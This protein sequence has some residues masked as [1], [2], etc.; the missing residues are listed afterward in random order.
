M[1]A[2]VY[3][4]MDKKMIKHQS[5]YMN[6]ALIFLQVCVSNKVDKKSVSSE[7]FYYLSIQNFFDR[8]YFFCH[9][10]VTREYDKM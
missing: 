1:I 7:N 3:F 4:D 6:A 2:L 9:I 10:R 5:S 8:Q